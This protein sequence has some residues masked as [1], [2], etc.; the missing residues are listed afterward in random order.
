MTPESFAAIGRLLYG[1]AWQSVLA[2]AL[3]VERRTVWRWHAGRHPIPPAVR[4]DLKRL[5][6]DR[7]KECLRAACEL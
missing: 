5:L 4:D 6:A 2:E 1:P 7:A 3:E